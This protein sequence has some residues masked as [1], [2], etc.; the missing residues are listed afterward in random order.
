MSL[1]T[2]RSNISNNEN[3]QISRQRLLDS[4]VFPSTVSVLFS[5]KDCLGLL[6]VGASRPYYFIVPLL[7]GI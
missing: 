7:R 2:L 6:R 4:V 3:V 5:I 1:Y